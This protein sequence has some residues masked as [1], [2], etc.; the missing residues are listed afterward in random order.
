MRDVLSSFSLSSAGN[1]E[2]CSHEKI[3]GFFIQEVLAKEV[4]TM[5]RAVVEG[6]EVLSSTVSYLGL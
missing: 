4:F 6:R 1:Q 2:P 5:N 3:N